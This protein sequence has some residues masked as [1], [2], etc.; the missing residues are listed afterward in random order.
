ML[1]WRSTHFQRSRTSSNRS[2]LPLDIG[3]D[4]V[5]YGTKNYLILQ[6]VVAAT[7]PSE[8]ARK[9]VIWRLASALNILPA[10]HGTQ[11]GNR[12]LAI[13]KETTEVGS[14]GVANAFGL[15]DMHGNVWE[16]CLDNW[17]S[18]YEGAP[19]DG[20][21]WLDGNDNLSQKKGNA[22]LRGG[23]WLDYPEYCRSAYRLCNI[24]AVRDIPY[25]GLG[26]RIACGVGSS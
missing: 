15:Y 2:S 1:P 6:L 18:N 13:R 16:W 22:V 7:N 11:I 12:P 23:S 4:T 21:A 5:F 26:F 25:Y 24:R 3:I 10:D 9:N 20:S 8:E 19:T 17:H 14:F